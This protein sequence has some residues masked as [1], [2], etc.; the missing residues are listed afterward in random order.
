MPLVPVAAEATVYEGRP[1][2]EI[3]GEESAMASQLLVQMEMREA[4]GGMSSAELRFR[5]TATIS[6]DGDGFAF[7]D[8]GSLLSL[9]KPLRIVA[10]DFND[11]QEIF[12][13]RISAVELVLAAG[14]A[15]HLVV[16]AEDVLQAA[17]M[18]RRTRYREDGS[19]DALVRSVASD[20]GLRAETAGLEA[21]IGPQ[22]QLNETDLGFLRRVLG[23][24]DADLQVVE[25]TIQVAARANVDRGAVALEYG[26]TLL[27]FRAVADL[28]DQ[29]T[30][31]GYA[32]W[33]TS[34]SDRMTVESD[35]GGELGAGDGATG[36]DKLREAFDA[37]P[38]HVGGMALADQREAQAYVDTLFARRARRFV[39]AQCR[40][41]GDP[42]IRVGSVIEITGVGQRFENAYSVTEAAHRFTED[43]GYVTDF[44]AEC[45]YFGG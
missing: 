43:E 32:G 2:I 39:S 20:L 24:F 45:A 23:R 4:E 42:S 25:E 38:E 18:A 16:F 19:L 7:E 12:V 11:P 27:D 14:A 30:S 15:P 17:R 1:R 21:E 41:L 44:R 6:G 28:A 35:A 9:G 8:P 26:Q 10:G 37:R 5:N 40:S 36:A 22:L 34:T 31:V 3:E 13:G 33:D 29:V